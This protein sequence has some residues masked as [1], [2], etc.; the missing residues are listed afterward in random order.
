MMNNFILIV[1]HEED[2]GVIIYRTPTQSFFLA[3]D[4][5]DFFAL[6]KGRTVE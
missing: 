3:D 6:L 5:E 2:Y 4:I 1:T